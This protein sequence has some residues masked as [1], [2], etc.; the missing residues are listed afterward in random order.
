MIDVAFER[1]SKRNRH[2]EQIASARCGQDG[3]KAVQTAVIVRKTPGTALFFRVFRRSPLW[4]K[5]TLH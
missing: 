1:V 4:T 5:K 3:G 2:A